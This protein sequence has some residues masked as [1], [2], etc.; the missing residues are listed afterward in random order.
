MLHRQI[1]A[2]ETHVLD[3]NRSRT[4]IC[5]R[6]RD[7]EIPWVRGQEEQRRMRGWPEWSKEERRLL[8][9]KVCGS[10]SFHVSSLRVKGCILAMELATSLMV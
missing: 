6:T 8:R 10:R 1:S 3:V 2:P 4:M 9:S 5:G 7:L